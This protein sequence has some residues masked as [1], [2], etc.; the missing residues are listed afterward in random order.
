M[1]GLSK[2]RA[3][4]VSCTPAISV[5]GPKFRSTLAGLRP[6]VLPTHGDDFDHALD[7]LGK[8]FGGL[9]PLREA[10]AQASPSSRFVVVDHLQTFTA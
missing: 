9:I 2:R 7:E 3:C 10:V 6:D 8:D 1:I 4:G 5:P